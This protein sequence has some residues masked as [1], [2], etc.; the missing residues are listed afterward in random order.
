MMN[1]MLSSIFL[2]LL[3]L[4]P[5]LLDLPTALGQEK[6]VYTL[7]ASIAEA[8]ANNWSLKAR[9]ERIEQA[10]NV[11]KQARADFFPA[12]GTS[13]TYNR[14]DEVPV[15]ESTVPGIR[16]T[17]LGTL[18]N[19]VWRTFITQP[20]FSGFRLISS[21]ELSKLGIDQSEMEVQLEK[22]DL[23]LSVKEAY[24]NI[25]IADK[26]VEVARSDVESRE[27]QLKVAKSF[28]QV[29]MIPINDLLKAEVDL[30]NAKQNLVAAINATRLARANFNIVLSRP[31]DRAAEVED[32]LV[33]RPEKGEFDEYMEKAMINRPEIKLID[34]N[35]LQADQQIKL[36]GSRYYPDVNIL[37]EYVKA[38]DSPDVSGSPFVDAQEWRASA[39]LTWTL[40]EWGKT[41]YSVKERE[42][43][44]DELEKTR[45]ALEDTIRIQI[46][47][48][49]LA[50][51]VAETNIP[52]TTKAVEQA[53]ENLRVN[54]ERYKAQVTTMTEVLDAQ[55]LLTRA[56]VNY[57]RALYDHN[58][59]KAR[60]IRATG[61][62]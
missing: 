28:Y 60:L 9:E 26:A 57:Y 16:G 15:I 23:A 31:I 62:Y 32:I 58:L 41:H 12:V 48:A 39:V 18:D 51:E 2:G 49:M 25:I 47:D 55:F 59:A 27:S 14:L 22:L 40:W 3:F 19:Y 42:S 56:R 45:L 38:G 44:K 13:Y 53:E 35:L 1:R 6:R 29:G 30:A 20:V 50:L 17:P 21:F 5:V 24:F 8:M 4:L 7:E 33:Y 52:T 54:E 43:F 10:N 37:Y 11:K 61:T 34:I 36:A 46:K